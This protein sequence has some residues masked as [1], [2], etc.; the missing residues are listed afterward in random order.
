MIEA[1]FQREAD[2]MGKHL[3]SLDGEASI[4][5][6][7][8]HANGAAF[9]TSRRTELEQQSCAHGQSLRIG[10]P[11]DDPYA[12]PSV[13]QLDREGQAAEVRNHAPAVR[14]QLALH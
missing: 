14:F 12:L 1:N 11:V 7:H 13:V 8:R 9:S 10:S 2:G 6:G 5:E 4:D 3:K